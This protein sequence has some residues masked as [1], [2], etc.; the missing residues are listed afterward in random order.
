MS[1]ATH[2]QLI[3]LKRAVDCRCLPNAYS[4]YHHRIEYPMLRGVLFKDI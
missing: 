1:S 2:H 3:L 4:K